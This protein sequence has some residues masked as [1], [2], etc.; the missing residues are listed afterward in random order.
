MNNSIYSFNE[1]E[2]VFFP[3]F[4]RHLCQDGQLSADQADIVRIWDGLAVSGGQRFTLHWRGRVVLGGYDRFL[5]FM[6]V[7]ENAAV[8]ARAVVDGTETTLFENQKGD[9]EPSEWSAPLPSG[10]SIL[11]DV[12]FDFTFPTQHNTVSVS[13]LGLKN[14]SLEYRI[15]QREPVWQED[16]C[17]GIMGGRFGE[18]Q[19]N[20]LMTQ[21]E[22]AQIRQVISQN[23]SLAAVIRRNA[24]K[25]MEVHVEDQMGEYVPKAD[26]RF[27][28]LRHRGRTPMEGMI[29]DLAL[30]G[31]LL[32]EP[33]YSYQ[34]A[35]MIL[36]M[37]KMKWYEGSV[38]DM[39]GS[40]FHHVCF[41]ED[42]TVSE[43][44][45]AMGFM[46]GM[47]REDV[48]EQ[49]LDKVEANWKFVCQKNQE[50]GYRNFMNQGIVGC[51]G[52]MLG[53]AF[54]HLWR[55]GYDEDMEKAYARHCHLL[56]TYL[57]ENGHCA[58][59]PGYYEYS[60]STSV[61]LWHVYAHITG[62]LVQKILPERFLRSGRYVEAML[63][64]TDRTGVW[65]PVNCCHGNPMSLLLLIF[66]TA[67]GALPQGS[68]YLTARLEGGQAAE[69]SSLDLLLC[70]YYKEQADLQPY[71]RP[72][73]EEFSDP[74]AGLLSWRRGSTKLVVT[75]ER[76]PLTGHFHEDRGGI[77]LEDA[78]DI[79]LPDAGTV[80]YGNTASLLMARKE[81][82]NLACP[83][84]MDM[85][86]ESQVGQ[87]A[88]AMAGYPV[89]KELSLEDM[90]MPEP[91]ILYA[92][93]QQEAYLFGVDTGML[94][95]ASVTGVRRGLLEQRTLTVTDTWTFP[96]AHPLQV[97]WLSHEPWILNEQ[98]G[99]AVSGRK[100]LRVTCSGSWSFQTEDGLVSHD[101]TPL[102]VL[103]ILTEPDMRHTV[104]SEISW[105]A[106]RLSPQNTGRE[107]AVILQDLLDGGGTVGIQEP[108]T[109]ELEDTLYIGSHTRLIFGPGVFIKRSASSVGSF[110]LANR[111]AFTRVWDQDI[112][113]EGLH[114]I[115][116]GVEA[117]YHA[118]VYGLTGELSFFYVKNLRI[119][120]FTCMDL[121]RLSFG[122]HV[123][124]FED[125]VIERIHVEGRKDAVH[126]GTGSKF[127][128]RHGLFR[129][130]DDPIALNA[131][132]Y[133]VANP[134]MGWIEDGLIEDCYDLA[135][136]D[137]TGYFC[138]ILAGAWV[139]WYP[140][141]EIQ[142]SD[143]VV[144]AGRVYRAFQ[145][146]DGNRYRSLTPPTHLQ[147]METLDGIHWVMVQEEVTYQCGCRNIHFKDIHLQK[148]REQALSIH[149]DHDQYSRSV[150]PGAQMPVQQNLV[151]ENVVVQNKISCL[152]RSITPVDTIKVVNSVLDGSTVLL[153]ALPDQQ[154]PYP[155]TQVLLLG[156]TLATKGQT[157]LV[158]SQPGRSCR[159]KTAGNLVLSE[160][161]EAV[162][163][164]DVDIQSS[165]IPVAMA[166]MAKNK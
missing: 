55:G 18:I 52:Q 14:S 142:N 78:D 156:N 111:G 13:W 146:P 4:D 93:K 67:M 104:Q 9:R 161:F 36:A 17:Q 154:T 125:L 132:D 138:R 8:N 73:E 101:L 22:A 108:G 100:T 24:Q 59:G 66:M 39:E 75:A 141:M 90:A 149:F 26:Y 165:D 51:R 114:L 133:A 134:Q 21:E 117:R 86:A 68:S 57:T 99:T 45:L 140:G 144:S 69:S 150:Y 135:D 120:D 143:T 38:C 151:F 76:N 71:Y 83:G 129:T 116:N 41:T 159:L 118:G 3:A 40:Q 80:N 145:K 11:T 56:E 10:G 109:Y 50:P 163:G 31:Y 44:A 28:R 87:D 166:A 110:V 123:C 103:R 29:L 88:A 157:Y 137:T 65:I 98:E 60:F 94:Y 105:S 136:E 148:E 155:V 124:T 16:W 1:A 37:L 61:Q 49:I 58:E 2:G 139:D 107:N 162:V 46:G 147:G 96:Q 5:S 122:I 89:E 160:H 106:K 19:N 95:G 63:S 32:K 35:K 152:V 53:A 97:T 115:T 27:V 64:S 130:F 164:G 43:F 74:Q 25:A 126:L 81:Y 91:R 34:A 113:L 54:L 47:F 153:E 128:I 82:H 102:Y 158:Q 23:E 84:D 62:R 12:F 70:E 85:T 112:A 127:V 33:D 131:H 48:L 92:Q 6:S 15:A 30:A 121:P 77:I 20:L 42:H 119:F 79:L 7:P 72:K